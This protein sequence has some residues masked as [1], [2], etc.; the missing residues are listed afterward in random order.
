MLSVSLTDPQK[1]LSLRLDKVRT[2]F[3]K[4]TPSRYISENKT[5]FR[6]LIYSVGIDV[7]KQGNNY[8]INLW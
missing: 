3:R 1:H 6:T 5:Y 8:C 7:L 4:F 2:N